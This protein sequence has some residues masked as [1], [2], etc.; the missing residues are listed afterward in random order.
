M[1]VLVTG[2]AWGSELPAER[3]YPIYSGALARLTGWL[4]A[5]TAEWTQENPIDL[6][7]CTRCNACIRA[8]PEQAIDFSYQIDLDRCR[9]HRQCVAACGAIG[10]IDFERTPTHAQ[11]SEAFDLVLDLQRE[12]LFTMHQPPQGYWHPGDDPA[13]QAAAVV[14][15]AGAVGSFE[16]PKFFNY[17]ASHLRPFARTAT[18]LQ[19]VPRGVLDRGHSCR[20]RPRVASS[21]ICAWAV[22]RAR[23]FAPPGR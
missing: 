3:S 5:F 20:R 1:C 17:K 22:A 8:C 18:G 21:R 2:R 9:D 13:A 12:P 23:R 11:R 19:P 16:K 14:D 10:A 7:V 4:G 6:D 15:L